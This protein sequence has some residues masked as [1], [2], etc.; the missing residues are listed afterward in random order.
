MLV[1]RQGLLLNNKAADFSLTKT[2][3]VWR[4]HLAAY[5]GDE[6]FISL[7]FLRLV[8]EIGPELSMSEPVMKRYIEA[9]FSDVGR[10]QFAAAWNTT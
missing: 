10:P 8:S 2:T 9:L 5:S 1:L 6:D 7:F 4:P 3:G